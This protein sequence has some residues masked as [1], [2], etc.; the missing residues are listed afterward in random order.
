MYI[1]RYIFIAPILLAFSLCLPIANAKHIIVIYDVSGSMVSPNL[2][3]SAEDIRRVNNYLTDLLF[4][5]PPQSL[6]NR[7]EFFK[8]SDASFEDKPL[9]QSGDILTFATYADRRVYKI[10]R[11]QVRRAEFQQQLPIKFPGKDSDLIR[12]EV[13]VYDQL[14]RPEDDETYWIFVTDDDIDITVRSNPDIANLLKRQTE[15]EE[16]YDSPMIFGIVVKDY[17]RIQVRRIQP[18]GEAMFIANPAA[19]NEAVKEIQLIKG[20]AGQFISEFLIIDTKISNKTKYKLNSV[21]VE[22]FDQDGKPLQIENGDSGPDVLKINSVSLHGNL[23]PS[24]FKIPLSANTEIAAAGKL[25]LE[26]NYSFKSKEDTFSILTDYKTVI[27]SIYISNLKNPHQQVEDVVLRLSEGAYRASVVVRSESPNKTEFRIDKI[28][29]RIKYKDNRELCD[30]SVSTIPTNLDKQFEITVPKVKDLEKYGNKLVMDI[31]YHY[32]ETAKSH[33]I[34]TVFDPRVDSG[35]ALLG[36]LMIIGAI[37]LIIG[38]VFLIGIIRKWGN[39]SDAMHRIK[40]QMDGEEAKYFTLNNGTTVSFGQTVDNELSFNIGST[41][42][43]HCQKGK[44]KFYK[45]DYDDK[46][47]EIISDVML[48]ILNAEGDKVHIHFEFVK[49]DLILSSGSDKKIDDP[50][51]DNLLPS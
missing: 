9:Y 15:I 25:K 2:G 50:Y 19:P 28:R 24:K 13:E 22:I 1:L 46:G 6:D 30:V 44:I 47:N 26:V 3:V 51:G 5:K 39:G 20:E 29:C 33:T 7:D 36:I 35:A 38:I 49:D 27:D 32:K 10:N 37:V 45:D 31:D 43:I 11:E 34:E 23:P 8:E 16:E 42:R 14:Y 12:A 17:I 18:I 4:E 48:E 41:A 40:L 21:D